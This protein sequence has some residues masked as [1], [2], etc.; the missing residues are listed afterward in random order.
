[1]RNFGKLFEGRL[2]CYVSNNN[3]SWICLIQIHL[4]GNRA[5]SW[6]FG[7][8]C[9]VLKLG[10]NNDFL[11]NYLQDPPINFR[12]IRIWRNHFGYT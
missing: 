4:L 12:K 10:K 5:Q 6:L 8:F 1:M 11:Q 3:V 9:N 2:I 7:F